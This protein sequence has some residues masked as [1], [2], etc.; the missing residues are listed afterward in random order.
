M[1]QQTIGSQSGEVVWVLRDLFPVMMAQDEYEPAEKLLLE[2]YRWTTTHTSYST[3]AM[4]Q[5]E[6][7]LIQ[8][9]TAWGK[10]IERAHWEAVFK[11]DFPS[12]VDFTTP[13]L[14]PFIH[15]VKRLK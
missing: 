12:G 1:Y 9:Y 5:V 2:R 8:L 13:T 15:P 11:A 10:P 6:N 3:T 4:A 7:Q 14:T